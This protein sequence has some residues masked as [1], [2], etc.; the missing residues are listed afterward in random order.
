M[1]VIDSN[2]HFHH[3]DCSSSIKSLKCRKCVPPRFFQRHYNLVMHRR[4]A[5][6]NCVEKI[7]CPICDNPKQTFS[8]LGNLRV[9][10]T[11]THNGAQLT[12]HEE[13]NLKRVFL[14]RFALNAGRFYGTLSSSE[15][16]ESGESDSEDVG[17]VNTGA[18]GAPSTSTERPMRKTRARQSNQ[19]TIDDDNDEAEENQNESGDGDE[20]TSSDDDLPLSRIAG[21]NSRTKPNPCVTRSMTSREN[22]SQIRPNQVSELNCLV[23]SALT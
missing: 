3:F 13:K 10:Y 15:S 23:E 7:L 14:P 18:T 5:H 16:G 11:R 12:E 4:S 17:V 2:Y 21:Q 1:K 20:S 22:T 9:H 19:G 6:V 8:N